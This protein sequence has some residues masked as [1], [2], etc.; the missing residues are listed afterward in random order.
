MFY[1]KAYF[2]SN[3]IIGNFDK[4][5]KYF[6]IKTDLN[7]HEIVDCL[8]NISYILSLDDYIRQ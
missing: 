5:M 7:A 8:K 3:E 4:I 6:V 1:G 2:F